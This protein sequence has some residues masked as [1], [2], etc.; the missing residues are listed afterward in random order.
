VCP[1]SVPAERRPKSVAHMLTVGRKK[2]SVIA[3]LADRRTHYLILGHPGT[4]GQAGV[5]AVPGHRAGGAV[6]VG[7]LHGCPSGSPQVSGL[8]K[9]NPLPCF[10]G[11]PP[12]G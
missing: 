3:T 2:H 5:D 4:G 8:A 10:G 6:S 1:G 7:D 9:R 11:R 12:C